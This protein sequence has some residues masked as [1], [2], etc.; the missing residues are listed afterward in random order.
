MT[1]CGLQR[2]SSEMTRLAVATLLVFALA[3]TTAFAQIGF[4]KTGYY[5]ALGDSVAAGT[6]ALPV[7]TGYAY[8]LYDHGVFGRLQDIAFAN[9]AV[10]AAR[11]WEL[12]EHQ[13][14]QLLCAEPLQRP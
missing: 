3:P 7:T 14:P 4:P 12:L 1:T 13:V 8:Q 9:G 2:R 10:R 11:T 6:G 5:A